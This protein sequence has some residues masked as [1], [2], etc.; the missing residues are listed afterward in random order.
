MEN[1]R[2]GERHSSALQGAMNTH[3]KVLATLI[4]VPMVCLWAMAVF[5]PD[6]KFYEQ[7]F[8]ALIFGIFLSNLDRF[9]E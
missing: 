6:E 7:A 9:F 8:V 2:T 5:G 1:S 3:H 4:A